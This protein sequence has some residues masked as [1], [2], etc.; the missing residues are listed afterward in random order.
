MNSYVIC[1]G[2]N[3]LQRDATLAAAVAALGKISTTHVA[4]R[5]YACESYNGLGA[6]YHNIVMSGSTHIDLDELVVLTK[7]LEVDAGRLPDSKTTGI[8]PLDV[9]I[10][11]WNDEVISSDDYTRLHFIIG[12]NMLRNN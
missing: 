8:M 7:Q 10:V 3:T 4:T 9:D 2:S 6:T 1:L 12:Y 11:V 5:P